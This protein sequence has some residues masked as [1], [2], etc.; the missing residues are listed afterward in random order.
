VSAFSIDSTSGALTPGQVTNMPAGTGVFA[1]GAVPA[2]QYAFT[3]DEGNSSVSGYSVDT[4]TGNLTSLATSPVTGVSFPFTAVVDASGQFLYLV[5]PSQNTVTAFMIGASGG[6]TAVVGSPFA[7]GSEP[8]GM[9]LAT[10]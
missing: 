6:L 8:L 7:T 3:A 2:G 9:A 5:N 10:P 1:I 4:N